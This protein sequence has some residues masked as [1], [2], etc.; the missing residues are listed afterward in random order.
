[1]SVLLPTGT[2]ADADEADPAPAGVESEDAADRSLSR[3]VGAAI[4]EFGKDT[5]TDSWRLTTSPLQWTPRQWGIVAVVGAAT[6]LLLI[7]DETIR[8][9]VLRH[10]GLDD[11]GD[12]VQD[13]SNGPLFI[14]ALGGFALS[15]VLLERPKDLRT[16]RLM[17][18]AGLISS[19]LT[20]AS[21]VVIGR[22]RIREDKGAHTFEPFTNYRSMP[23]GETAMA[24]A[25]ASVVAERYPNWPVRILS[26]GI[27]STVGLARVANDGHWSS[28]VLLG[29]AMGTALGYSVL[30]Y[31]RERQKGKQPASTLTMGPGG[32]VFS[33]RF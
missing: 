18:E 27:A 6:G 2:W 32:L 3:D 16:S 33:M 26:Y 15:G 12:G 29:A 19:G 31:D 17:L 10:Q 8:D 9:E 13:F 24:F 22:A 20:F 30:H 7:F 5:L 11:W 23:S 1:M 21:K 28:D 25:M 4:Y 14:G